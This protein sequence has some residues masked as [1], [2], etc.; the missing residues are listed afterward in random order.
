MFVIILILKYLYN[1]DYK[2]ENMRTEGQNLIRYMFNVF[3][4]NNLFLNKINIS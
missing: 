3:N 1:R 2:Y 4:Y